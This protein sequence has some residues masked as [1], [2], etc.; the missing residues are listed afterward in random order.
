[1]VHMSGAPG[2]APAI[3]SLARAR[4]LFLL[5]DCAQCN[6]GSI[7]G[8]KVGTFGDMG[9]FSYQMNKNMTAGEGGGIVTSD[10][11][12]YRRAVACHDLGY[13]RD[14]KGRLI[15][16]DPD[17]CLWGRGYRMD[18]LR[19]AILRVQL[20]KL[21]KIIK[22]MQRSKYRIR[23]ALAAFPQVQLRRIQDERAIRVASSS[24]PMPTPPRPSVL[25]KRCVRKASSPRRKAFQTL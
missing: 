21:P 14:E 12:L 22:N 25:T 23:K 24:R 10:Q 4:G 18:E 2:D 19:A 8:K 9:I 20:K 16:D 5:E 15:F 3:Q 1:L 13:A 17:L 6:G 11:R 7:R